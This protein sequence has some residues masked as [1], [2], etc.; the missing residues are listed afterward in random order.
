M[1]RAVIIQFARLGDLLQ[2]VPAI[3]AL[4]AQEPDVA[5]DLLCPRSL[6]PIGRLLPGI[7]Q[8][9]EWDGMAWGQWANEPGADRLPEAIAWADVALRTVTERPYDRAYVLNQ[10]PRAMLAA[11][12]IADETVGPCFDVFGGQWRPWA[13]YIR[14]VAQTGISYR[15][16]L[17]D[18]FCGLMGVTPTGRSIV[19]R[20]PEHSLPRDL[21]PIGQ[22]PGPWIGLVVGA[23][24]AERLVPCD[25]LSKVI[26]RALRELPTSRIV[27]FGSAPERERARQ[28]QES[29]PSSELGRLW[30]VTGRTGL[31]ELTELLTR[32]Q[33]VI[34][35]DTGPLHLAAAAGVR[36][37]GWYFARARVHETGPYGDG[38][39]IFQAVGEPT[40][41]IAPVRWPIDG[42][43]S[44]LQGNVPVSMVDW[45]LWESRND[46][47][48]AYYVE[49]GMPDEPPVDR[50]C[51]WELLHPM[52][53]E[54]RT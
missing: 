10:H 16:H 14:R 53:I 9:R 8:V 51:T 29:L 4:K 47:W 1:A 52:S 54:S 26:A 40:A 23:G 38:H 45:T 5:L 42:T 44:L 34:S 41:R 37:I 19:I 3:L 22:G 28:V 18:A 12:L 20:R 33:T 30:D 21:E 24:E 43:L 35:A 13:S 25:V 15:V 39:R 46:R 2:T 48:G 27:L 7:E 17:A 50:A 32:C 49:A 36:T 6:A 31:P 11:A